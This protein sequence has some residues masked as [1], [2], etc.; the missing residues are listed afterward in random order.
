M[1][2][3]IQDKEVDDVMNLY[4]KTGS[5]DI[6]FDEFKALVGAVGKCFLTC[7][8]LFELLLHHQANQRQPSDVHLAAGK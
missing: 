8:V 6:S 4:D 1:Q 3:W 5:G 7:T 2:Q